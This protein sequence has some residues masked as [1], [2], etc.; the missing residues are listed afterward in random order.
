[1]AVFD[2]WQIVTQF[3]DQ[4]DKFRGLLFCEQRH[5]QVKMFPLLGQLAEPVLLDQ[6]RSGNIFT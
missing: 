2:V 1:M 6:N 4:F 5:L 3:L